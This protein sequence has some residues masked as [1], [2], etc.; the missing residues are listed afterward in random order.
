MSTILADA[1]SVLAPSELKTVSKKLAALP[2][3]QGF[4]QIMLCLREA[5]T[6]RQMDKAAEAKVSDLKQLEEAASKLTPDLLATEETRLS[7]LQEHLTLL[8][9]LMSGIAGLPADPSSKHVDL[10]D[11][12]V[13]S[14][15]TV[16]ARLVA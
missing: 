7:Q 6:K 3:F 12:L 10:R 15:N 4:K 9:K 5:E 1:E 2:S 8:Q 14:Q 16:E 13:A 11:A